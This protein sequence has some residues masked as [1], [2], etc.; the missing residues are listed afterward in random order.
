M[1]ERPVT[2]KPRRLNSW[3]EIAAYLGRGVR[4]VQRWEKMGLP[5]QRPKSGSRSSVT[6]ATD[7]I[8]NWLSR[9][10]THGINVPQIGE[11]ERQLFRAGLLGSVQQ[12]RALR[13]EM[14]ILTQNRRIA[15]KQLR[16]TIAAFKKSCFNTLSESKP[17]KLRT[18]G[19]G[20]NPEL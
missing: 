2:S 1:Q 9:A 8:D 7:E 11:R 14:A 3:K 10:H 19:G 5:V 18:L 12:A 4:T 15:V 17:K 16:E 13:K 20:G 6:A